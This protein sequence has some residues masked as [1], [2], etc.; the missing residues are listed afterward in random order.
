MRIV[1]L[2][3]H[4]TH[5]AIS[6]AISDTVGAVPRGH[7][8]AFQEGLPH[9]ERLHLLPDLGEARLADMDRHGITTQVLSCLNMFLPADVAPDATR[10]ANDAVARA[11]R[12]HPDRFA[13]FA[14]LPTAVPDVAGEELRRCVDELGFVGTMIMGRTDGLFLDDPRFDP[15]LRAAHDHDVPI[16]LHP[17]PPPASNTDYDGLSPAVSSAFRLFGWGWHQ[18]TAVHFLHLVLAGV[19]DRY[20]R[21]RFVLGHWGEF[22]PFYLDRLDASMPPRMTGL[23]RSFRE[24]FR[25][26]VF[27]TPSGMFNQAQLR[28][29]VDTVGADRI[30]HAVDFPMLGNEGAVSFLTDSHL[31]EADQAKIA[32]QNADTLLGLN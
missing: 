11:V 9:T 6:A 29:C 26:N 30:I 10:A 8:A 18:E 15:I 24:Y 27:I 13:A 21:L 5:P 20:P 23:D 28:Y 16:Y 19:L 2:E 1:T 3:E 14:T 32:H 7:E 4:W 12:E 17:A 25:E 31:S 22:V